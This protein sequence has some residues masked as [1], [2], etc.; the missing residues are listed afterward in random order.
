[1]KHRG[2]K[3]LAGSIAVMLV[4]ALVGFLVSTNIRVNSSATVSND[5]AELIEQRV[6]K[7]NELQEQVNDLS[8]QVDKLSSAAS[9]DESSSSTNS[10]DSGSSTMLPAVEGEGVVVT[11]NDSSLWKNNVGSSGSSADIDNYVVHQQDVEAVVDALWAGGAESMEIMDQRVLSN[12]A[13]ICSGTVLMLQG[14]KYSPPFTISAIGP[15][16]QMM[17]ALADSEAIQIYQ[18]YVAVYGLGYSVQ[19][20]YL[21]FDATPAILT[22]LKYATVI[23]D[24]DDN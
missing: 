17:Q 19:E 3:S 22:S 21:H 16:D 7:V 2:R 20:E 18:Q 9:S 8:A 1:M 15:V 12:S 10:E 24:D 23:K 5:T 4:V 14:K 13:V 11:L 6:A